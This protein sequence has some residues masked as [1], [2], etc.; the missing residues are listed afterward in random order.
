[1]AC[2][3]Q[4]LQTQVSTY[5]CYQ[6]L[7][8]TYMIMLNLQCPGLAAT[9]IIKVRGKNIQ[10]NSTTPLGAY[11][12]KAKVGFQISLKISMRIVK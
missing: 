2:L 11:L 9:W 7:T 5:A 4:K 6:S 8:A 1:M 3:L 12:P 10:Y